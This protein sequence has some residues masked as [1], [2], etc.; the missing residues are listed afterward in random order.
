MEP[1]GRIFAQALASPIP[2]FAFGFGHR[3]QASQQRKRP[4]RLEHRDVLPIL[5]ELVPRVTLW[6]NTVCSSVKVRA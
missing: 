4:H 2:T 6:K 3:A 5:E 1:G